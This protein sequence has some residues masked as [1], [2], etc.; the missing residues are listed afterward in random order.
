MPKTDISHKKNQIFIQIHRLYNNEIFEFFHVFMKYLQVSVERDGTALKECVVSNQ[1]H[2]TSPS[3][4]IY[5]SS[6][7]LL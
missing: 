2:K 5:E 4:M 1:Q 6:N 7:Q 3:A